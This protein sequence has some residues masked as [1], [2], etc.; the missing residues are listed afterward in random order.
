[1][2]EQKFNSIFAVALAMLLGLI[3]LYLAWPRMQA[4]YRFLPVDIA[5]ERYFD[6]REIPSRRILTLIGFAGEAIGHHDHYRYHNGLSL[7]Y[8]LRGLDIHTPALERRAAYRSAETEAMETVK[9]APAQ[10]EAWLRMAMV[11]MVLRDEPEE[12]IE[13]WKMSIFTGRTHST[14]LVP[15]TTI[16]LDYLG[17]LDRES[18]SMLRDQ[19]LLAWAMKPVELLR[20]LKTNDPGLE[21]SGALLGNTAPATLLEMEERIEKIH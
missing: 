9:R 7:L 15:R 11:R 12:V 2:T 1:M 19:L 6:N 14:L 8:Y 18:R 13:P 20:M 4:S 17:F 21:K 10:P 3:L 16:G 5:I